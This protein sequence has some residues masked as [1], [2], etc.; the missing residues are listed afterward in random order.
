MERLLFP[1]LEGT[2]K[3][4]IELNKYAEVL[5]EDTEANV[6]LDSNLFGKWINLLHKS[7]KVDYS[8]G[9]WMENREELLSGTYLPVGYRTHLGVDFWV[10][11]NTIVYLPWD[12]KLVHH[13]YDLDQNGGWGGQLIF[14]VDGLYYIFGHLKHIVDFPSYRKGAAIGLVAEIEKNGGWYPHLHFQCIKT[15]NLDV[16]GYG[17]KQ[18]EEFP[19]PMR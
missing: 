6:F 10:P 7:W 8:W 1:T 11:V 19:N 13:R 12:A 2:W 9:G 16:D 5:Q 4:N 15:L 17:L 3:S 18:V 14:E